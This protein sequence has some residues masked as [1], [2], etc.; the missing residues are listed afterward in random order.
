MDSLVSEVLMKLKNGGEN[1][2]IEKSKP[3]SHSATIRC[4]QRAQRGWEC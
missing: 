4:S 1:W 2:V 3:T